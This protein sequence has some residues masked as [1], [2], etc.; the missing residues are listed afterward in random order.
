MSLPTKRTIIKL[1]IR[2]IENGNNVQKN[3]EIIEQQDEK[4]EMKEGS[5]NESMAKDLR[6]AK[7]RICRRR[8]KGEKG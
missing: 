1:F 3:R 2:E 5:E 6:E 8:E 7:D 4:N